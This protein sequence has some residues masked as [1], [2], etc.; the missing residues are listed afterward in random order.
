MNFFTL[1]VKSM[2]QAEKARLFLLRNGIKCTAERVTGRGGCGF[3]LK[4]YGDKARVCP[5][6]SQ[7]GISCDIP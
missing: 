5:L 7:V 2:T 6:L 4:I 1:K 3:A